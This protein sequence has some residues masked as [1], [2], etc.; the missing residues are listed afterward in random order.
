M[1]KIKNIMLGHECK[2]ID[3]VIVTPLKSSYQK[4][5]ESFNVDCRYQKVFFDNCIV[6]VNNKKVLIVFS[7]QGISSIDI[8]QL[9]F[10]KIILFFGLAGGINADFNIGDFVEVANAVDDQGNEIVLESINKF[11]KVKCGYSP[12]LFG[13][14]AKTHC[15]N[16]RK[17]NCDVVDMET[18]Y[19][20]K[21]ASKNNNK[22]ISLLVISDLPGQ[23]NF[24]ELNEQDIK[25]LKDSRLNAI[26]FILNYIN[27][28]TKE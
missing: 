16:A 23:T 7:P 9:F 27:Y 24:W 3:I 14:I 5:I 20:A 19:C 25:N 28:L 21:I 1:D 2:N 11:P 8:I 18:A 6:N 22:F 13:E 26:E 15:D 17:L 4:L 10:N 12:C